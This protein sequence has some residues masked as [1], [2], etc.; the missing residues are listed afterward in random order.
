MEM[1]YYKKLLKIA[2]FVQNDGKDYGKRRCSTPSFITAFFCAIALLSALPAMAQTTVFTDDFAISR[3][4][5]YTT[6]NG[7]VGT[8]PTWTM[9]R[10]GT[11][12]GARINSGI[13]S[14]SSDATGS[15]NASGWV[16]ASTLTTSSYNSLYNPVLNANAGP[17]TWTFNM[18]Q[19]RSNPSGPASGY[20]AS[21]FILAGTSSTTATTGSGYAV[22]FG[23]SGT[24]DPIRII[25]YSAGLRTS[26]NVL[27]TT[28]ASSDIG[29]QYVSYKVVYTPSTNT[30]QVYG[31]IDS[32]TTF[33]DPNSGS[34][35]LIGSGVNSLSTAT[36][37]PLMGAYWNA[38]TRSN[39]SASFD[40]IRVT[41]TEPTLTSISPVS[42]IANSGQ[43]TLT[44]IGT[45]FS[46]A[47]V[48]RWNGSARTTTYVSPTQLTAVIPAT[49]IT[50][51]GNVPIT[52]ATGTSV[53][54]A[55]T[56]TIDPAAVPSVSTSTN[57]VPAMLT[58]TGT[59]SGAQSFTVTGTNLTANVTVTAPTNFEVSQ[60]SATTG[61]AD[62]QILTRSGTTL[63]T[64]P[65][66]IFVRIK[67]TAAAAALYTGSVSITTTGA[68][69]KQVSVSGT[70]YSAEPATSDASL[71][72]SNPT[73]VS[74]TAT[75]ANGAGTN[76]LVVVRAGSAVNATPADG[77]GYT[78][79]TM[80]GS[81]SEIGTGNYVVY[82]G[83]AN[84]VT[85][86]GLSPATTYH[87]SVFGFNGAGGTQNYKI[88]TPATGSRLTLN[89]PVG[90]QITAANV[91]NTINF[92]TTVEG[93]NN[94]TF[95]AGGI[96]T[97]PGQGELNSNAWAFTGFADGNIAFG[98]QSNEESDSYENGT[99][100]G[101]VA[102]GGLYAF[103]V[104][105]D[106]FALGIQPA[107]GE[108]APGTV[109]LRFQ[110]QTASAITSLSIGYKVYV[111]NDAAGSNSLNFS[112]SANNSTYTS[113]TAID[114][115]T[116]AAADGVPGWKAYYKVITLTGLNVASNTYYYVRWSGATVSG[117]VF[118]EIALDDI[119]IVANPTTNFAAFN[120]TAE[121]FTVAGNA[122]MNGHV[123][124]NGDTS[125]LNSSKLSIG[126]NTLTLSGTVTNTTTG[127]LKGSATSNLIINGVL[128]PT[129]SFD[130]T[131]P[132]TSN[133][134]NT[135]SVITSA[136]NTV[137]AGN[138][139]AVNGSLTIDAGQTLNLGTSTLT[140]TLAA[141]SN[142]GLIT[143]QNTTTTPFASGKTW[144]GTGT[145]TLNA[146]A[147]QTLVAGTYNN[148]TVGNT[149]GATATGAVTVNGILHLPN[150]NPSAT[151]GSLATGTNVLTM[152]ADA[153]NTGVGDV[154]G[155]I[156]RTSMTSNVL[157][158]FGHPQTAI[159]FPPVGTLPTELTMKTVLGSA[160]AGKADGIKRT[161]DF[162]RT[163]GSGTK[164]IIKA[165]YLDS[166]LNGNTENKLVDWVV[167]VSP[168]AVIEQSRTN[169]STTE[170]FVELANVNIAFFD[171]A[172]GSKLLTLADSQVV[173]SVWNGSVSDSWVTNA[174][175]TPNAVPNANTKVVIPAGVPNNPTLAPN[176]E[177]RTLTIETGAVV[178]STDTATLTITGDTGAWF[179]NGTFN[180]GTGT[181]AVIFNNAYDDPNTTTDDANDVTI[182]GT[183]TFN[184]ITVGSL[185]TLR[186][187]TDNYM[188]IA[189]TFTKTGSF[190]GGS[191]QNTVEYKGT[192]Q[193]IITPNGTSLAYD[194]LKITGTGAVFPST[195]NINGDFTTNQAVNLASTTISLT[196]TVDNQIIGG[197]VAPALSNLIINKTLG[198]VVLSRNTSVSGTLT[199]T[200]GIL[201]IGSYDLSLGA[202]AVAGSF[203]T[204]AM[205]VAE[206]TGV[207]RRPYTATG[208][209]F[210]PLGEK[211]SNT[212]YTPIAVNVTSGIF[213][214]AFISVNLR[215]AVH[216]NSSGTTNYMTR[217][218][219]VTQTGITNAVATITANYITGDAVGGE[220]ALSAAQ[221]NGTFNAVTNPWIKFATPSSNTLTAAGATLTAGQTSVFT[222][223]EGSAV[224]VLISGTGTFC[225]GDGI[226]FTAEATGGTAPY[227]YLWSDSLGTAA[228][229]TPPA[230]APGTYNYTLTVRDANGQFVT[231][232]ASVM[233]AVPPVAGTLSAGSVICAGAP[234]DAITVSGYTGT[235]LRW[236]R[237]TSTAF[238]LVTFI[239]NTT[240]TLSSAEIGSLT[241]TRY[242]RAV[243]Q[244][245]SCPPAYTDP[246]EI[247]VQSTTW[248]GSAWSNG[249]P[250]T[251]TGIIF[252]GPYTATS[253]INACNI[254][255]NNGA[256]VTIPS[257]KTVT[258]NGAV[259]V[260]NGSF[261]LK[262][263]AN[264]LQLTDVANSGNILVERNSSSLYRLD[265]TM[266]ASPVT[267]TNT[268]Q[269]FSPET[270]SNRF[271]GYN[272][273]SDQYNSVAASSTFGKGSG[274]LIRMPNGNTATGYNSGA[275][276]ITFT[277]LFEGVPN[278]GQVTKTL[279]DIGNGY[280]MIGNPFPSPISIPAF[281]TANT[282]TIDGTVWVWRKK[283]NPN[284]INS[285]YVTINSTG[286]YVGNNEP[287]QENPSG[288]LRTG[289]GFI[290]KVKANNTS[291]DV[292]FTNAMRSNNIANQFFRQ[293]H[294]NN[295]L[296]PESHGIWLNLTNTSGFYSQMY[297]GYIDGATADEDHGIDA[298]YINDSPTV[299]AA[300]INSQEYIIQGRALPFAVSDV[301]PL[302]LR[303]T[304]AGTYT[305]T[306][307]H[308]DG[309]FS[310]GQDIF[311]RDK[312][313]GITHEL[314]QA[315]YTFTTGAGAFNDRFEIIYINDGALGNEKPEFSFNDVIVYKNGSTLNVTSGTALMSDITIFDVRG[316]ILY[317]QSGIKSGG[318][319]IDNL[320]IEQQVIIINVATNKGKASKK[321]IF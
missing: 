206:G 88:T 177:I 36:S 228:T 48:I 33:Q 170:N 41:V 50:S 215:D 52:V 318:Y 121:T 128:S 28:N 261:I 105:P 182:G 174:N 7:A 40:N 201:N 66:T 271:M 320:Q 250:T 139:F 249:A 18:R 283:N 25:R 107:P 308:V 203:S 6:V 276:A 31:R 63:A 223:I 60:T 198:E 291:D 115:T 157:Y 76:H 5:S 269:Q 20:Y 219:S 138:A 35:T 172:F 68:A 142:N 46:S 13:L 315:A 156:K 207:V 29:N 225:Q 136:A 260:N 241:S 218:W 295:A 263:N 196:G 26:A 319:E 268:L 141:I 171:T 257:G 282:N 193:M 273:A 147:A 167:Q 307:D 173:T 85:I 189:G 30:W 185:A 255:V 45:N 2:D 155:I 238:T 95:N 109:T 211:T 56:F 186:P 54:A 3:G 150:A 178:N 44:V 194:N 254:T 23:Q 70:V 236:E 94:D 297:T 287:E 232:N 160:P 89:A 4:T 298:K 302:I 288:I 284:S 38:G 114:H 99:S 119:V 106:N 258:L 244:N 91:T 246:V 176:V 96:N 134:F 187:V 224:S 19:S 43:F 310:Q 293:A 280:N 245:G 239:N 204:S 111:Y 229:A 200:K 191:V 277:G 116:G 299:L 49:D 137:T 289:Q 59:A 78:A 165:H 87:V 175:W 205:I 8:S 265:Y 69:A 80:F 103:E 61:F 81:G 183:T 179:N 190:I 210:F 14:L 135:F 274:Y 132:G 300:A 126:A 188:S 309:L 131:T 233:I 164:A 252:T 39:Q 152:G 278:N 270:T 202:N 37:L 1:N 108:F 101:G 90:L 212:S 266:W 272:T 162:I 16:L 294:N 220:A 286:Q 154:S 311:I 12:F 51:A 161:Y 216:P 158:T 264:L 129:L 247:L 57:A 65:A 281:L 17:I 303:T 199:L 58:T 306:I 148:V 208:S 259:T 213:S 73:S 243:I 301:V 112:H 120:G 143:T 24:T 217:Y 79:S 296:P 285:A 290:V 140:G 93:V 83:T 123:T 133:L 146:T 181:S 32:T 180:P 67:S 168:A 22:I 82:N 248:D 209:Y 267:G 275:T 75:W 62:A 169:Y 110:N 226:I 251:S 240:A 166:E 230:T 312:M 292:T 242:I 53:T 192:N 104:A 184:N 256:V 27:T 100:E 74:F 47:S 149:A 71:T 11:D 15:T 92:D 221:L 237:A 42:R 151:A 195:L 34:L 305:I 84:T 214:N 222:A 313:L 127:G 98:G 10:S 124:V 262:N 55:Q 72:F 317:K 117:T 321:L 159:I 118:D 125:F 130:Q 64:S 234:A 122:D 279:A 227:T 9:L 21:A 316:R 153:V 304:N 235:V 102:D 231:A 253:D 86:T 163:G 113:V 97:A 197:T 77:I 145:V 314:T 144:G